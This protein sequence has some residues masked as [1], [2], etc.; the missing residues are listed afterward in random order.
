M[1][2]LRHTDNPLRYYVEV[3][4]QGLLTCQGG[5]DGARC[6]DQVDSTRAHWSCQGKCFPSYE[7]TCTVVASATYRCDC[8]LSIHR[9]WDLDSILRGKGVL[10]PVS[11][12]VLFAP[13]LVEWSSYPCL[14]GITVPPPFQGNVLLLPEGILPVILLGSSSVCSGGSTEKAIQGRDEIPSLSQQSSPLCNVPGSS[15]THISLDRCNCSL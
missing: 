6:Y 9:V 14:V 3:V 13:N 11:I 5:T 4:L 7:T 8:S 2:M 1:C 12:A 10:C 15:C